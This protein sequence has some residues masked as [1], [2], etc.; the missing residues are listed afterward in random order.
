[1][2]NRAEGLSASIVDRLAGAWGVDSEWSSP[3]DGGFRWWAHRLEQRI[4]AD[5]RIVI[6]EGMDVT[7]T[8]LRAETTVLG[9]VPDPDAAIRLLAEVNQRSGAFALCYERE[10]RA[11]V[12]VSTATIGGW[13]E[14]VY[15]WFS[16]AAMLQICLAERWADPLAAQ[17]GG[18]VAASAHPDSGARAKPDEMLKWIGYLWSRP[19]WVIGSYELVPLIEP[20]VGMLEA[21]L[22]LTR[23]DGADELSTW[24]TGY[25]FP[26]DNP[27]NRQNP[28]QATVASAIWH[29]DL[30]PGARFQI[31][32]P[33]DFGHSAA[34]FT[35]LLNSQ[36]TRSHAALLGAWWASDGQVGFTSFLPQALLGSLMARED[37]QEEQP[38][39]I[40][41]FIRLAALGQKISFCAALEESGTPFADAEPPAPMNGSSEFLDQVLLGTKRTVV[42]AAAAATPEWSPKEQLAEEEPGQELRLVDP[43]VL[44]AV[45]G[46]FNPFGPTLNAI[47][48]LDLGDGRYLLANWM[49][50]PFSP[51]YSALFV[52]PDLEPA[53]V[54]DALAEVLPFE[55]VG[56]GATEFA[57][58]DAPEPLHAA[59]SD[60]FTAVAGN[61]GQL[62]EIWA[63]AQVLEGYHGDHW[64]RVSGGARKADPRP[65]DA[66]EVV[67]RWWN[68]LTDSE[69]F[70]GAVRSL[71]YAWD[72]AIRFLESSGQGAEAGR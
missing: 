51:D 26:L 60:A 29:P 38:E 71:P 10:R 65:D 8:V 15:H 23:G 40:D 42:A 68:A 64:A 12:A 39:I 24:T 56:T 16:H 62:D 58:I 50:H 49:R 11:V 61:S 45:F 33:F 37:L 25:S 44:L 13:F 27:W 21:G 17:L 35:N 5:E 6:V 2:R 48:A 57:V 59:V 30:G 4:T 53:T 72:G 14:T 43:D 46:T 31:T 52:L 7:E 54:R 36:P 63:V 9:N 22:D 28:F 1:M 70:A 67:S 69:N 18:K 3:I 41:I 32:A 34:E 20:L 19:E 47:G 66:A 55:A